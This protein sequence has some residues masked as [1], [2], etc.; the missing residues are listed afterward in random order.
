MVL[1]LPQFA[2]EELK[3]VTGVMPIKINVRPAVV[4]GVQNSAIGALMVLHLPQYAREE[5]KAVT[6]AT[7]IKTSARPAVVAGVL[8]LF[9]H[10]LHR[11]HMVVAL[12]LERRLPLDTGTAVV[13]PVDAHTFHLVT[14]THRR[15]AIQMPCF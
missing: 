11:H 9:L 5:L 3:A 12:S 8:D 4:A 1:H 14:L 2:M 15:T 13:A 7:P 6:G 10:P